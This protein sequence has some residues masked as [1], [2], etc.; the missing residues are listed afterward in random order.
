[1]SNYSNV[2]VIT[3]GRSGSTLLVGVLNSISGY[4]IRGENNNFVWQLYKAYRA[5]EQTK[6]DFGNSKADSPTSPWY[7]ANGIDLDAYISDARKMIF[8]QLEGKTGIFSRGSKVVG[9]KEIRYTEP[10]QLNNLEGYLDFLRAVCDKPAFVFNTRDLDQVCKSSWWK[11]VDEV[12]VK[13]KLGRADAK[14]REVASRHSDCIH[15]DY[16]KIVSREDVERLFNFLGE[17]YVETRL[18]TVFK[19]SHSY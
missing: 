3:Y 14:F 18:N 12:K 15:V 17:E 6:K 11:N 4:M 8:G 10:H 5:L 1:M 19:K 16:E 2:F 13:E 9:F 7:G